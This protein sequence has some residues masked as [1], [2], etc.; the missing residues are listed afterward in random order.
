MCGS[1]VRV[2][3]GRLLLA[4]VA[5]GLW[6]DLKAA[7]FNWLTAH[8]A[9]VFQVDHAAHQIHGWPSIDDLAWRESRIGPSHAS[10]FS[11]EVGIA[12]EN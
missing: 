5:D 9:E 6:P 3:C 11:V 4:P 1:C 8:P 10:I 12:Y 7:A 2:T